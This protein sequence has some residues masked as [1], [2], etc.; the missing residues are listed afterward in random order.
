MDPASCKRQKHGIGNDSSPGTQSPSSIISQNRSVRLNFLAQ[1]NDLKNGSV[2][3]DYKAINNKRHEVINTLKQLQLVPIKL[4]Y[5][6]PALKSSGATLHGASQS[7]N[8]TNSDDVI[9]MDLHYIGGHVHGNMDNIGAEEATFVVDSDDKETTCVV[10]SDANFIQE[11]LLTAQSGQYTDTIMLDDDY[12]SSEV[13]LVV[14][15]G[16]DNMGVDSEVFNLS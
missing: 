11:R 12:C 5:A 9:N 10:D 2:P 1:F 7:E 4:R 13:Q 3:E 15:Q 6:S 16:M 8:N 14:K